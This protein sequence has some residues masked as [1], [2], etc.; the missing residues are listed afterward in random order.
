MWQKYANLSRK[1]IEW[2]KCKVFT[3]FKNLYLS[4]E[5][6]PNRVKAKP[7]IA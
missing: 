7:F 1:K 2:R 4:E 6:S 5:I 3:K